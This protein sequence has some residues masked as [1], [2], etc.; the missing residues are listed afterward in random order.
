MSC[1]ASGGGGSNEVA[2]FL[3]LGDGDDANKHLHAVVPLTDC[4]HLSAVTSVPA[5]GIDVHAACSQCANVGENWIC[6]VC[7]EVL[8]RAALCRLK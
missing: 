7:Y 3:N 6:L 5:A 8:L 1:S 4:P 2:E